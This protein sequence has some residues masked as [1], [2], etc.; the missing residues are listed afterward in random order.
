MV[1]SSN[2]PEDFLLSATEVSAEIR[3]TIMFYPLILRFK[4][5]VQLKIVFGPQ[6]PCYDSGWFSAL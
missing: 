5:S 4:P 1:T 2:I 6:I 3:T